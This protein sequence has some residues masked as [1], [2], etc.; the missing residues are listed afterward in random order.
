[1]PTL[2]RASPYDAPA[3]ITTRAHASLLTPDGELL[4]LDA[5]GAASLLATLPAPLLIHGPATIRR[6]DLTPPG[7]VVPWFDLL[8]LF[9][10]LFPTRTV[11][12][13][14]RGM[15]IALGLRPPEHCEADFLFLLLDKLKNALEGMAVTKEAETL[16]SLLPLLSRAGWSWA[17]FAEDAL[18]AQ[19]SQHRH[20]YEACGSGDVCHD[21]RKWRSARRRAA[22]R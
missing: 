4:S 7:Q 6:L 10:F 15:G 2:S 5:Q 1:M 12:P 17:G 16:R 20:P 18:A 22:V 11:V 21:G 14:P 19:P 9:L 8:E 3:L 13:T